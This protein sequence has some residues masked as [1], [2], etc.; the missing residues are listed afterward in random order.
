MQQSQGFRRDADYSVIDEDQESST[1]S[2]RMGSGF[3]PTTAPGV[4]YNS[5]QQRN[6]AFAA[7]GGPGQVVPPKGAWSSGSG[8]GGGG[9]GGGAPANGGGSGVLT[10]GQGLIGA[11]VGDTRN[12]SKRRDTL[13]NANFYS[14]FS[15]KEEEAHARKIAQ[16]VMEVQ[17]SSTFWSGFSA[18]ECLSI[19]RKMHLQTF[20][21]AEIIIKYGDPVDFAGLLVKGNAKVTSAD[22]TEL[23][24]LAAGEVI[25]EIGLWEGGKRTANI[26]AHGSDCQVM[27]MSFAKLVKLHQEDP[28][29]GLK[30]LQLFSHASVAKLRTQS[31]R[32][33]FAK[34]IFARRSSIVASK[35]TSQIYGLLRQTYHSEALINAGLHLGLGDANLKAMSRVVQLLRTGGNSRLISAG[36]VGEALMFVLEGAGEERLGGVSGEVQR[37]VRPGDFV[38]IDTFLDC[39]GAQ[40]YTRELVGHQRDFVCTLSNTI[41]GCITYKALVELDQ[42]VPLT[43]VALLL[44]A[45]RQY[46]QSY[47]EKLHSARIAEKFEPPHAFF[48]TFTRLQSLGVREV[49]EGNYF[50]KEERQHLTESLILEVPEAKFDLVEKQ[51]LLKKTMSVSTFWRQFS[52]Q[53]VELIA[54]H[55]M[56]FR[57]SAGTRLIR[58]GE[59]ASFIGIVLSGAVCEA[60][61]ENE[62]SGISAG[63]GDIFGE[64]NIFCGSKRLR[65]VV[66][67]SEEALVLVLPY[68]RLVIIAALQTKVGLRIFNCCVRCTIFKLHRGFISIQQKESF[69]VI[70]QFDSE[71]VQTMVRQSHKA[72][73]AHSEDEMVAKGIVDGLSDEDVEN[74]AR[75]WQ[76]V[77]FQPRECILKH[78]VLGKTALFLTSGSVDIFVGGITGSKLASKGPGEF[79]GE[80]AF[81]ERNFDRFACRTASV[82]AGRQGTMALILTDENLYR[83][84]LELPLLGMR[85]FTRFAELMARRFNPAPKQLQL[86]PA[87]QIRA[88]KHGGRVQRARP[89]QQVDS[90]TGEFIAESMTA[91]RIGGTIK[92]LV[93]AKRW[94]SKV[95]DKC[96]TTAQPNGGEP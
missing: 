18:D 46:V 41:V 25:G 64:E 83:L 31:L 50:E 54:E 1:Q 49:Q 93:L 15:G 60:N 4:G 26:V 61:A 82:F 59:Q 62:P 73:Q 7:D 80:G 65:D 24:T 75:F 17:G 66:V 34:S 9:G 21:N 77:E 63:P 6:P 44:A 23:T 89:K 30:L 40:L 33:N 74:L 91:A 8:S 42:S 53:G 87:A 5:R 45:S 19:G 29:L 16:L 78:N 12:R 72:A 14:L 69:S 85:L 20:Q 52:P 86:D 35:P 70:D 2:P 92:A 76:P 51:E 88:M 28:V 43:S 96:E 36:E 27:M 22:G 55:M 79:V 57:V 37:R 84:N 81:L 95:S 38:A 94:A 11:I 32:A 13:R 56:V 3:R 10:S 90:F 68:W 39:F 58:A 71:K 47:M 67:Q 48:K